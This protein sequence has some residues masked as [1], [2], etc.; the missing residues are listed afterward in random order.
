ME[1]KPGFGTSRSADW[2]ERW[3][4]LT[5]PLGRLPTGTSHPNCNKT[6]RLA[7]LCVMEH[8]IF[9]RMRE[10]HKR[11]DTEPPPLGSGLLILHH[12]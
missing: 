3:S 12:G 5:P 1:P 9:I 6:A 2:I 11:L 7:L 4:R 10:L 8:V